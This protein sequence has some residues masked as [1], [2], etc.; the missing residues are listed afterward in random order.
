VPG[1]L[2][3]G[4]AVSYSLRAF[5]A[6]LGPLLIIALVISAIQAAIQL[7]QENA[8]PF[9]TFLLGIVG[10]IVSWVLS[11]GMVQASLAVLDGRKPEV[12]MLFS[13]PKLGA[14][15]LGAIL[16]GVAMIVGFVLCIIP[17]FIVLFLFQLWGYALVD[18]PGS[19]AVEAIKRSI[20]VTRANVGPVLLLDV[21]LILIWLALVIVLGVFMLILPL[22]GWLI[23]V[24]AGVIAYPIVS[25]A[26]A[27][28][29][30]RLT[31]GAVAP[32]A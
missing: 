28:A 15:L 14:Y 18:G 22:L 11:L 1:T 9:G 8:S 5:R 19:D 6:Y 26:L 29:W 16:A 4:D 24:F 3:A 25:I 20:A 30:R 13:S 27:Y 17:G 21:L 12:S 32:V 31:G 7:A 23:A 2:S 10:L